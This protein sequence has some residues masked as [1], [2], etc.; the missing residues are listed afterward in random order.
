MHVLD[1]QSYCA[2]LYNITSAIIGT[3][4]TGFKKTEDKC[5][6]YNEDSWETLYPGVY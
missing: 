3:W 1:R 5:Q 4:K 2:T 6:R